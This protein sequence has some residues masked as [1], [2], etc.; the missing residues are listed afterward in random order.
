MKIEE[1][2]VIMMCHEGIDGMHF[3]REKTYAMITLL[4]MFFTCR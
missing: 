3:G 1:K 2:R 4:F